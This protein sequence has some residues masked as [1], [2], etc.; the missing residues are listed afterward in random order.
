MASSEEFVVTIRADGKGAIQVFDELGRKLGDLDSKLDKSGGSLGKFEKMLG[1]G[2]SGVKKLGEEASGASK[3]V[4]D[5]EGAWSKMQARIVSLNQTLDLASRAWSAATS[6]IGLFK[7]GLA[8]LDDVQDLAEKF[9]TTTEEMS[10]WQNAIKL[11]DADVGSF[12]NSIWFLTRSMEAA[13]GGSKETQQAFAALGVNLKDSSGKAKDWQQIMLE[14]ADASKKYGESANLYL[15]TILGRGVRDMVPAL[16]Q[17]AEGLKA[18]LAETDKY[19]ANVTDKYGR[20]G[21]AIDD[22]M[23]RMNL[24]WEGVKVQLAIG[25]APALENVLKKFNEINQTTDKTRFQEWGQQLGAALEGAVNWVDKLVKRMNEVGPAA[26]F[27][28]AWRQSVEP[29]LIETAKKMGQVFVQTLFDAMLA[30][31][32]EFGAAFALAFAGAVVGYLLGG[33]VIALFASVG[34]AWFGHMIDDFR[35]R[36][37]DMKKEFAAEEQKFDQSGWKETALPSTGVPWAPNVAEKTTEAGNAAEKAGKQFNAAAYDISIAGDKLAY[38]TDKTTGARSEIEVTKTVVQKGGESWAVYK[39][40]LG[41]V[42]QEMK[43]APPAAQGSADAIQKLNDEIA[44]STAAGKPFADAAAGLITWTEAVRQSEAIQKTFNSEIDKSKLAAAQQQEAFVQAYIAAG[45]YNAQLEQQ[46]GALEAG[47]AAFKDAIAAGLD[48]GTAQTAASDAAEDYTRALQNQAIA[49]TDVEE[50]QKRLIDRYRQAQAEQAKIAND[51]GV[52]KQIDFLEYEI[53]LENQKLAG[54]INEYDMRVKLAQKMAEQNGQNVQLAAQLEKTKIQLE[55]MRTSITHLGPGFRDALKELGSRVIQGDLDNIGDIFKDMAK[56]WGEQ[57]WSNMIDTKF[58]LF[59]PEVKSNFLDLAEFGTSAFGTIFGT[60]AKLFGGESN[61]VGSFFTQA[62]NFFGTASSSAGSGG[63]WIGS[64]LNLFGGGGGGGG[65][66]GLLSSVLNL[67]GGGG[68]G[69]ILSSISGLFGGGGGGIGSALWQGGG[70]LLNGFYNPI[71]ASQFVG[72]LLES[73]AQGTTGTGVMGLLQGLISSLPTMLGSAVGGYLGGK[74]GNVAGNALWGDAKSGQEEISRQVKTV[75]GAIIGTIAGVFSFGLGAIPALLGSFA[76][77]A[78]SGAAAAN[79]NGAGLGFNINDKQFRGLGTGSQWGLGI[80]GGLLTYPGNIFGL[81]ENLIGRFVGKGAGQAMTFLNPLL[82]GAIL[83]EKLGEPLLKLLF[84]GPTEGTM[85]RRAGESALDAIPTFKDLQKDLGDVRR[86]SWNWDDMPER[87]EK[88]GAKS[89][90]M[91]RGFAT[92]FAQQGFGEVSPEF[93]QNVGGQWTN[94]LT[95]LFSRGEGSSAEFAAFIRTK[96]AAAFTD[97]GIDAKKGFEILNS[98]AKTTFGTTQVALDAFKQKQDV[99]TNFGMAVRGF[100]Y[101]MEEGLPAGVHIAQIALESM[102]KNG[103]HLFHDLTQAQRENLYQTTANAKTYDELVGKLAEGGAELD[104]ALIERRISAIAQSAQFMGENLGSLLQSDDI[105]TGIATMIAT[106]RSKLNEAFIGEVQAQLFDKTQIAGVFEEAFN[107]MD[108]IKTFDFTS[109]GG[110]QQ[111]GIELEDALAMGE[112]R[113]REYVPLLLK[114]Q[115]AMKEALKPKTIEDFLARVPEIE[116]GIRDS[117][118]QG[119]QAALSTG[120]KEAAVE[121]FGNSLRASVKQNIVAAL[122]QG[123]TE[124]AILNS[125]LAPLMAKLQFAISQA[126]KDGVINAGEQYLL[127]YL[128]DQIGTETTKLVNGLT[129][130]VESLFDIV[131]D[132]VDKAKDRIDALQDALKGDFGTAANSFVQAIVDG[133]KEGGKRG[134]DVAFDAFTA[135]VYDSMRTAILNAIVDAFTQGAIIE[136]ALG[137]LLDAFKQHLSAA[138]AD[139]ILTDAEKEQ[140]KGDMGGLGAGLR[141]AIE[142]LRPLLGDLYDVVMAGID[143]TEAPKSKAEIRTER[144]DIVRTREP[145]RGSKDYERYEKLSE[146]QRELMQWTM[147]EFDLSIEDS[148][149]AVEAFSDAISKRGLNVDVALQALTD[150]AKVQGKSQAEVNQQYMR[151]LVA[152][153]DF[154]NVTVRDMNKMSNAVQTY[155]HV[156]AGNGLVTDKILQQASL[157]DATIRANN[158]DVADATTEIQT[159]MREKGLSLADATDYWISWVLSG[160]R[161]AEQSV[162]Q[163]TDADKAREDLMKQERDTT[164]NYINFL[165]GQISD[166]TLKQAAN[167]AANEYADMLRRQGMSESDIRQKLAEEWYKAGGDAQKFITNTGNL[168]EALR[169]PAD[170]AGGGLQLVGEKAPGAAEGLDSVAG[171]AGRAAA[172]LDTIK[173]KDETDTGGG[174]GGGD[175]NTNATG[176]INSASSMAITGERGPELVIGRPNGG[177]TVIPLDSRQAQLL[178]GGGLPGYANGTPDSASYPTPIRRPGTGPS[179]WGPGGPWIK[180]P[181]DPRHPDYVDPRDSAGDGETTKAED[182]LKSAISDAISKG[183]EEGETFVKAFADSLR[184]NIYGAVSESLQDAFLKSTG[185]K[186][187]QREL[188]KILGK[189]AGEFSRR[190]GGLTIEE[191]RGYADDIDAQIQKAE[192]EAAKWE[193]LFAEIERRRKDRALSK[194]VEVKLAF[195][196]SDLARQAIEGAKQVD[197]AKAFKQQVYDAVLSGIIEAVMASGPIA[198]EIEKFGRKMSRIITKALEDGKIDEEERK[199]IARIARN[200]GDAIRDMLLALGPVGEEIAK[201]LGIELRSEFALSAS[202][203]GDSLKGMLSDPT[204]LNF[205]TF[206]KALRQSIYENVANGLIDAFIQSAVI[207]GALAVPLGIIQAAFAAVMAGQMSVAQANVAIAEQV[208]AILEI[209]NGPE[210]KAMIETLLS[211]ISDL[212]NGLGVTQDFVNGAAGAVENA[213]DATEALADATINWQKAMADL[214]LVD[215]NQVGR[216]GG[217]TIESFVPVNPDGTPWTGP[218]D[219][220]QGGGDEEPP[221][222]PLPPPWQPPRFARGGLVTRETLGIIGDAGPELVIPLSK[223]SDTLGNGSDT[224]TKQLL[225]ELQAIRKELAAMRAEQGDLS[226]DMDGQRLG[227]LQRKARRIARKAGQRTE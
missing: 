98:A 177:F 174:D 167:D 39:D 202:L 122:V 226:I 121:A 201:A 69:S 163:Q 162:K 90:S 33:P 142:F 44:K 53:E 131:G 105:E 84:H 144:G 88:L 127:G 74:V 1:G 157:L 184:D 118:S 125:A 204:K 151:N 75:I 223:V 190:G 7:D 178:L 219:Q 37:R 63:S 77:S 38:L 101:V 150:S 4:S 148:I 70:M 180:S 34:G 24:G 82:L 35:N 128:I 217:L 28:E 80:M 41:N 188:D 102:T 95:E 67:F 71:P 207:Q 119:F 213:A 139:G 3:K 89:T 14:L 212:A 45:K 141:Q 218:E 192:E 208:A 18:L 203:I 103:V 211:G 111:F 11:T 5:S 40:K 8:Q 193:E 87:Q 171:A 154:S 68:G 183:F 194:P 152:L 129:P 65:G 159:I 113:L 175:V 130:L 220:G 50:A 147:D 146:K 12:T 60:I 187:I 96:L 206:S 126:M 209:I 140:I 104:P 66:G 48:I 29:A 22:L 78:A 205:E 200:G 166:P 179:G 43:N 109:E 224:S 51:A 227:K 16:K 56:G 136:G 58:K 215:L 210:F 143:A 72:P 132:G 120:D 135:S 47:N 164:G 155:A 20:I 2:A 191:L 17:G 94:I 199:H 93:V 172:A 124:S 216:T 156:L 97:M 176:G 99:I 108:E 189:I 85:R 86:K 198:K 149:T 185:I 26:A 195:D 196:M 92:I 214:G 169:E 134:F 112:E 57:L 64:L 225:K 168:L 49:G 170:Y 153:G 25:I 31:V 79:S 52:Q 114:I 9:G 13:R 110:I 19:G 61:S 186:T 221:R 173:G 54:L 30:A 182:A 181:L 100:S 36:L 222:I 123:F 145:V 59:D 46:T 81:G 160:G 158:I 32:N 23:K 106:M 107:L 133:M 83:G 117:I 165:T 42:I 115:E 76:G 161:A 138:F 197:F 73:G 6:A 10:R 27:A 55:D 137:P 15:S 116:S 91:L 21:S 62:A